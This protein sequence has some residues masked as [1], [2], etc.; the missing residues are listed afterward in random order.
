MRTKQRVWNLHGESRFGAGLAVAR[1]SIYKS[2]CELPNLALSCSCAKPP[3]ERPDIRFRSV[4]AQEGRCDHH[5]HDCVYHVGERCE[6]RLHLRRTVPKVL[7]YAAV[8]VTHFALRRRTGTLTLCWTRLAV[9]PK[10]I[11]PRKRCPCVLIATRSQ[12]LCSIH[13]SISLTGSP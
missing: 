10:N 2:S 8:D 4:S 7:P 9:A 6:R 11:S 1:E 12:L 3:P 13:S 5:T